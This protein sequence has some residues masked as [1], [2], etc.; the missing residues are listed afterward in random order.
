MSVD[1]VLYGLTLGYFYAGLGVGVAF[2]VLGLGFVHPPARGFNPLF[3]LLVVPGAALLWPYV[4]WRWGQWG[5][6]RATS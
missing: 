2:A 5:W 4:L 3:R 1:T 6:G